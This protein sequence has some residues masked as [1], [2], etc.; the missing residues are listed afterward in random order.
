MNNCVELLYIAAE[1]DL[2]LLMQH[3]PP[4]LASSLRTAAAVGG[5]SEGGGGGGGG[6]DRAAAGSASAG[7]PPSART[8]PPDAAAGAAGRD[9]PSIRLLEGNWREWWDPSEGPRQ[10]QSAW[11]QLPETDEELWDKTLTPQLRRQARGG[12]G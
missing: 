3:L 1:E 8:G 12:G 7:R 11:Y 10:L 5:G 4:E 9:Q 2:E 6:S